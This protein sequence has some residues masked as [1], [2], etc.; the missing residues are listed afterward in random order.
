VWALND[1][2]IFRTVLRPAYTGNAVLAALESSGDRAGP[3][4]GLPIYGQTLPWNAASTYLASQTGRRTLN[5]Y[6]QSSLSWLD[7]RSAALAPLNQG[8]AAPSALAALRAVG[9][10]QVVV[11]DESHVYCCG[12]DWH[13]VVDRLIASGQFRLVADDAPFALLE[14][15]S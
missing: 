5:A 12:R 8:I 9:T 10:R 7:D 13:A 2:R 3:F 1:Y 4:L 14:L 15:R 6:N 11:I